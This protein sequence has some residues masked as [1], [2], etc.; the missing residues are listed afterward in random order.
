MRHS[1]HA[2]GAPPRRYG[3]YAVLPRL[4]ARGFSRRAGR[5]GHGRSTGLPG[6]LARTRS[7]RWRGGADLSGWRGCPAPPVSPQLAARRRG[8]ATQVPAP[9]DHRGVGLHSARVRPP[10]A[11]GT[12]GT[13]RRRGLADTILAPADH[14]AVGLHS[15]CVRPVPSADGGEGTA[16]RPGLAWRSLSSPQ[17]T[18]EP[19][20]F[21][22]HVCSCPAL[23]EEKGMEGCSVA[24]GT[25]VALG[26]VV[27]AGADVATG[28]AGTSVA[29]SDDGASV[30]SSEPPQASSS[31][32]RSS[33][34][35][36]I[37]RKSRGVPI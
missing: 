26:A 17:Q 7:R 35:A 28:A 9:A 10:S 34:R 21:T 8:L 33:A 25:V 15:A 23:T 2:L 20:V 24:A 14:R 36:K 18:N 31:N 29:R 32:G 30:G 6:C 27:A 5:Q 13:A 12:E 22:P 1:Q 37:P 4:R 3:R 19:S 16:R 11:D